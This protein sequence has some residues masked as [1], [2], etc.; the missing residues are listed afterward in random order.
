MVP[1]AVSILRALPLKLLAPRYWLDQMIEPLFMLLYF[2]VF[3]FAL[4]D[5]SPTPLYLLPVRLV[6]PSKLTTDS[7]QDTLLMKLKQKNIAL[8]LFYSY[9]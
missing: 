7:T 6:W 5:Y 8:A 3:R 2:G 4:P 1:P 9:F